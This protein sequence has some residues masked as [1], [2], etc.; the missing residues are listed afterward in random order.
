MELDLCDECIERF[1]A[2]GNA[3]LISPNIV[4]MDDNPSDE[5]LDSRR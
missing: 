5:F 1:L 2:E 3:E 4:A